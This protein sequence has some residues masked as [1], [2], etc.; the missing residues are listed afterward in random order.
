MVW[1]KSVWSYV[2]SYTRFSCKLT[3]GGHIHC[4]ILHQSAGI[5]YSECQE[6]I[7][8]TWYHIYLH[9]QGPSLLPVM[10]N[11]WRVQTSKVT[12]SRTLLRPLSKVLNEYCQTCSS[13]APSSGQASAK[14]RTAQTNLPMHEMNSWS[15]KNSL[16]GHT[17]IKLWSE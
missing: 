9:I 16:P 1:N 6:T 2:Q 12:R 15:L 14:T 10:W 4:I 7:Y 13:G 8:I 3:Y 5:L 17:L 11:F